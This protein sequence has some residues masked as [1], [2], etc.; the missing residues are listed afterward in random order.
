[1]LDARGHKAARHFGAPE[2]TTP[3]VVDWTVHPADVEVGQR[4]VTAY[5]PAAA[6]PCTDSQV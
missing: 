6:G 4:F 1:M 5:L 2:L 3:A